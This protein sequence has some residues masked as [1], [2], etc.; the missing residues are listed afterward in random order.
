MKL[1][2]PLAKRFI[3][4]YNLKSAKPAI[5]K[6]LDQGY[7]VTIDYV[8]EMSTTLED[9][10]NA[11]SE[12]TRILNLYTNID[13]S[14]KPSQLG[15]L[16]DTPNAWGLCNAVLERLASHARLRGNTIRLD[17]EDS[18]VT[19]DTVNLAVKHNVGCALQANHPDTLTHMHTLL[20]HNI[21][22]RLVKGAYKEK[23]TDIKDIRDYFLIY[24]DIEGDIT[25]ATHD[26][27]LLNQLSHHDK[28]EFLYGVRR[29]LQTKLRSQNKKVTIY[30]PYGENWLPYTLRRL[31]EWK[32]L[33]FVIGNMLKELV[34]K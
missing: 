32:N 5:N 3:A 34:S 22:I 10:Q 4:G 13:I 19:K 31:K 21:P 14:I 26:E 25:I 20:T 15:L 30:V 18:R 12:Y 7:G 8:G 27:I 23:I 1:L 16:I 2:Y 9:V 28:Y 24:A 29:D 17:M 6:L 33:K 11:Y